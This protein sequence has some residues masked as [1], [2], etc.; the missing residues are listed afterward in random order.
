MCQLQGSEGWFVTL[1]PSLQ[2]QR[3]VSPRSTNSVGQLVQGAG[4]VVK[5]A[6]VPAGNSFYTS[7]RLSPRVGAEYLEL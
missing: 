5:S 2:H 6:S 1:V 7:L 4:S 3:K